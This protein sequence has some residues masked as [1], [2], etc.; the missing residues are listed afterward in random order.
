MTALLISAPSS[1]CQTSTPAAIHRL[2]RR[3]QPHAT[4]PLIP[5]SSY[6]LEAITPLVVRRSETCLYQPRATP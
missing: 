2:V 3:T 4:Y 1:P 5:R 6:F